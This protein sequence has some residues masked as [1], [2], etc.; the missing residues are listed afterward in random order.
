VVNLKRCDDDTQELSM[1]GSQI[2]ATIRL[3]AET[4]L[5]FAGGGNNTV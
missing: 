4:R 2:W 1:H 3:L 5:G